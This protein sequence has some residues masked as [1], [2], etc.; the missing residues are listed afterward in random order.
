[1]NPPKSKFS[2]AYY[3]AFIITCS[4][5]FCL[6]FSTSISAVS[7]GSHKGPYGDNSYKGNP[8]GK[9][10]PAFF[11]EPG[12]IKNTPAVQK[13]SPVFHSPAPAPAKPVFT[14]SGVK[15]AGGP[16]GQPATNGFGTTSNIPSGPVSTPSNGITKT[17]GCTPGNGPVGKGGPKGTMPG[18]NIPK[19]NK[20]GYAKK[21]VGG[22][23]FLGRPG[24]N[25]MVK[26][27]PS[28]NKIGKDFCFVGWK[29]GKRC[30]AAG[31]AFSMALCNQKHGRGA[32]SGI[33]RK[34]PKPFKFKHHC[35][36]RPSCTPK[37][38]CTPK[39]LF[40]HQPPL[41][42]EPPQPLDGPDL[43]L[44]A[45]LPK[46]L[47]TGYVEE[48]KFEDTGCPALMQW[49]ANELGID[50]DEL[51]Q[52]SMANAPFTSTDIQPC[53]FAAKLK[54]AAEVLQD[55]EGAHVAAFFASLNRFSTNLLPISNE[56]VS[57]ISQAMANKNP[58]GGSQYDLALKWLDAF[59]EYIDLLTDELHWSLADSVAFVMEK[60]GSDIPAG[61]NTNLISYIEARV[62]AAD[63]AGDEIEGPES[64]H[65]SG[66]NVEGPA[67]GAD[68]FVW[69]AQIDTHSVFGGVGILGVA[70]SIVAVWAKVRRIV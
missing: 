40:P 60:Y 18:N 63:F 70:L 14:P 43:S 47:F 35:F 19:V 44:A 20:C 52:I 3:A 61:D 21:V 50:E 25:V 68:A 17:T 28:H 27:G 69:P 65:M 39:P 31:D 55:S 26:M 53:M 1:M 42:P 11:V 15:G 38:P 4:L 2:R 67:H 46:L 41:Q 49:V 7:A 57:S 30:F 5:A 59:V 58:D 34:R 12:V 56:Q 22:D 24:S 9:G 32:W 29:G 23:S 8:Y 45:P 51:L 54:N 6:R 64:G 10:G 37:P 13:F 48:I 16:C 62:E 36:P 66:K 33:C